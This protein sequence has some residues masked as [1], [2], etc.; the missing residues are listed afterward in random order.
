[1]SSPAATLRAQPPAAAGLTADAEP[2]GSAIAWLE[3]AS[4]DVAYSAGLAATSRV[5]QP[6]LGRFLR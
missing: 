1:M 2:S 3:L 6:S 4:L 5:V